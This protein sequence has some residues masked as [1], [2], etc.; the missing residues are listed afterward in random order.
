M[1]NTY[2]NA[3][4]PGTYANRAKQAHCYITFAVLYNVPYLYPTPVHVCMFSQFLANKFHSV[5]SVKNYISGARTWILELGGNTSAFT[6]HEQYMM[7]KAITKDSTHV[8]NRAFPLSLEHIIKIA[9]YLDKARNV[10]L[11]VKPCILIGFSC[12]LLASNLLAPTLC[13][14]GGPHTLLAKNVVDYG[15]C[16]KLQICST[17]TK[18]IPYSLCIPSCDLTEICPVTARRRFKRLEAP[19]PNGPAFVFNGINSLTGTLVVKLM[20]DALSDD[21]TIN[22]Q[23]ISMHSLRRGA[24]QQA[25]KM[26]SSYSDIMLRGGWAS[27]SGLKP[28]FSK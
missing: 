28:Y 25:A 16:L 6:G 17:K 5:A 15:S 10:P 11:C 1:I 22:V 4:A 23:Q 19:N 21:E 14:F 24:A 27:A 7:V 18:R 2:V 12:Y 13:V 3:L 26:G 9:A 8:P 20:R